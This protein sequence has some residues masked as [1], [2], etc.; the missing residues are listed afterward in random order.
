VATRTGRHRF[1]GHDGHQC[2]RATRWA[3]ARFLLCD[4]WRRRPAGAVARRSK[5]GPA[6]RRGRDELGHSHTPDRI[7]AN[8]GS[9]GEKPQRR[10]ST[11]TL[12][13]RAPIAHAGDGGG[14]G[15]GITHRLECGR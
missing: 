9:N 12:Q 5:P 7:P 8:A 10:T 1:L 6:T 13:V 11:P 3:I 4:A 15:A 14:A 2:G